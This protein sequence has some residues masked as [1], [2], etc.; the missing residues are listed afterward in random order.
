MKQRV[1][2]DLD[3]TWAVRHA[4]IRFGDGAL[5]PSGRQFVLPQNISRSVLAGAVYQS[6][7]RACSDRSGPEIRKTIA[8]RVRDL[9]RA[10]RAGKIS[11]PPIGRIRASN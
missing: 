10:L 8:S 11:Y 4:D 5:Y 2:G 9:D 7:P 1:I 6:G 3:S